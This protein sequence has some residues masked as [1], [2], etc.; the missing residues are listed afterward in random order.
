MIDVSVLNGVKYVLIDLSEIHSDTFFNIV[1]DHGLGIGR[2]N[3]NGDAR[4]SGAWKEFDSIKEAADY[5]RN[6]YVGGLTICAVTTKEGRD[7]WGWDRMG[8]G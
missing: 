6:N 1:V 4:S 3:C 5:A 2:C 8:M 7:K